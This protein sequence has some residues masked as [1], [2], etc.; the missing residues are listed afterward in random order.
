MS[1]TL[2]EPV[3]FGLL[4]R[5]GEHALHER[6]MAMRE[7]YFQAFENGEKEAPRQVVDYLGGEGSFDAL[8]SRM[9][10]YIVQTTAT[11]VLDMCTPFDPQ[12]SAFANILLPSRVICGERSTPSLQRVAEVLTGALA[13]ASLC[14]IP[15]A[16][17]FMPATHPAEVA[18]RIGDHV[19]KVEALAWSS[20]AMAAPFGPRSPGYAI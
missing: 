16:D 13:N 8:P 5:R 20:L 1:L 12:L 14:A 6:F 3:A 15:G 9:Q 10:Q 2:I 7:A 4:G 19:S 17:H 18:E 11:H